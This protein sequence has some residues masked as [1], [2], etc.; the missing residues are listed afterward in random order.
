MRASGEAAARAG[1]GG[2]DNAEPEETPQEWHAAGG[3][4][5]TYHRARDA[6]RDVQRIIYPNG[7]VHYVQYLYM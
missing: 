2:R 5:G 7:H 1:A 4:T 3:G 6:T